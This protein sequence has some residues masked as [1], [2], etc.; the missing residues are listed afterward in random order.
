WILC[1]INSL[2]RHGLLAGW[3]TLQPWP[4][5]AG[6][7]DTSHERGQTR[8][9]RPTQKGHHATPSLPR[10][11]PSDSPNLG[12]IYYPRFEAICEQH[13]FSPAFPSSDAAAGLLTMLIGHERFFDIVAEVDGKIVGSNFLDER[14]PIAGVGPVTVDPAVQ[15]D[16]VGRT[17]MLHV[18]ERAAE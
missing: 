2:Q 3:Q 12:N 18:M 15:N 17:L 10:G 1:H 11:D 13:G 5:P 7:R 8:T 14:N 9:V 6:G 4:A 16:G